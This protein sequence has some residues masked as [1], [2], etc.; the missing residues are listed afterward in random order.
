MKHSFYI[1]LACTNIHKNRK[2]YLPYI[3][4][5]IGM[6]MMFY[7]ISYL[8][9]D[10]EIHSFSGGSILQ[11][12]LVLGMGIIGI[13]SL[14]FLFYT[15]SFLMK[16]RKKEFGLFNILGMGKWHIARVML[17]ESIIVTIISLLFGL[18]TG[19]LF[20]KLG[21]LLMIRM[22]N[23][24]I[25]YS[26]TVDFEVICITVVLFTGIFLLILLNSLRQIH[27]S[28]PIELLN[29][30]NVGEKEPKANYVI[31]LLGV[32][33]LAVAYYMAVTINEPLQALI[34]FF[35]DVILVIIGTYLCFI[36]GSVA[37]CKL[38]R[39][40]KRYY[41]KTNHFISISGMIYRMK[42]NGAGLAAICIL[43][44]MV[45]VMISSTAC[46]YIGIDD[47]LR[48]RYP[49]NIVVDTYSC[50]NADINATQ[51]AVNNALEQF[52]ETKENVIEYHYYD[53]TGYQDGNRI[54]LEESNLNEGFPSSNVRQIFALPLEDYNRLA[55]E[56][57]T[58]SDD[59][60]FIYTNRMEYSY[61]TLTI[62]DGKSWRVKDQVKDFTSNGMDSMQII[63]ALYVIVPNMEAVNGIY[64]KQSIAYPEDA[65]NLHY[66]Y[67]FDMSCD[68]DVQIQ[69]YNTIHFV[70]KHSNTTITVESSA[71]EW[72]VFYSLYG[73]LFFLG[74]LLGFTF[75]LAAVLIMYYKQV[76]EGYDD[77]ERFTIL[78]KVGMTKGEIKKSI[79]S[80]VLIVFFLPL[81]AAGVHIAFAFSIITKLLAL[82]GLTNISLLILVTLTTLIIFA[83]FYTIIFKLTSKAYYNIVSG[84]KNK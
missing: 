34:W 44:T 65:S 32:I 72:H 31:A 70:L 17:Q 62:A 43:S 77:Q 6:V 29:G 78:Q 16:R 68:K 59:E 41:Y 23:K 22:L 54:I 25:T 39:R 35:V 82:F 24:E 21:Q 13:F 2:I 47:T 20:S 58:L 63:S 49:R 4:T 79:N 69:I 84:A 3:L 55:N 74:I 12:L 53:F 7:I 14:I 42:Q 73:G 66:Y 1:K 67:G 8:A 9:F 26:F 57:L 11:Q 81:L 18:F 27:I 28:K 64:E 61:D 71:N 75:L 51:Q 83:I 5:C 36:S 30:S 45:L 46:L 50:D 40:S 19:I 52:G 60:I 38:L 80:Q 37:L 76:S 10:K 15:N 33:I 48:T 56:Q